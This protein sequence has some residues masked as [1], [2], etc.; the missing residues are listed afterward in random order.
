MGVVSCKIVLFSLEINDVERIQVLLLLDKNCKTWIRILVLDEKQ[1]DIVCDIMMCHCETIRLKW[2][3][4]DV[5]FYSMTVPVR[6]E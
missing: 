5:K 4:Y 2:N 1:K 6:I 3:S